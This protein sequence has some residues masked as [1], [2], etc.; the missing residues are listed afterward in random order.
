MTTLANITQKALIDN[1]G[2]MRVEHEGY[3]LTV[4]LGWANGVTAIYT[5]R[6]AAYP[7]GEHFAEDTSLKLLKKKIRKFLNEG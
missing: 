1:N 3:T 2:E 7:E 4:D 5:A 6:F